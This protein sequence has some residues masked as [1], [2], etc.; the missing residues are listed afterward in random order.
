MNYRT[1]PIRKQGGAGARR[2]LRSG[3]EKINGVATNHRQQLLVLCLHTAD[4]ES[5]V[6]A[7]SFYDGT[8]RE[9]RTTGDSDEP[10]FDSVLAAIR[11][12]WRVVQ[13]PQQYPA[14]PGMEYNTSYLK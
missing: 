4:L 6:V 13:F 3:K 10:P 14:Y 11:A 9:L 5:R 2:E 12:G 1:L 7:W 8:G